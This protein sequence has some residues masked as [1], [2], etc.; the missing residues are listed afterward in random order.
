MLDDALT[1]VD[2]FLQ[3]DICHAY[4]LLKKNGLR[5]ENIVV[6]MA[7]DI[8]NNTENPK[9]GTII[10]RPGGEDVYAGV[11]KVFAHLLPSLIPMYCILP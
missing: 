5:D 4:Q 10:N 6:F 3:A 2:C 1:N 9:Q 7:D 8:A 11:P